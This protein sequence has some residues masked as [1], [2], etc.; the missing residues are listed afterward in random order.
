MCASALQIVNTLRQSGLRRFGHSERQPERFPTR[1]DYCTTYPGPPNN[2]TL[3]PLGANAIWTDARAA[4]T[5][6]ACPMLV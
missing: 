2:S 1:A 3:A 4:Y 5:E 6:S